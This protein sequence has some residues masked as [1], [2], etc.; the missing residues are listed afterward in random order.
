[1]RTLLFVSFLCLSISVS[2][3]SSFPES[4]IGNYE[5]NL[6]IYAVD[7][8]A[9]NL[10]MNLDIIKTEKD[11]IFKWVI[12]YD[13]KGK[14]DLRSYE[15]KVLDKQKGHYQIDEK[16]SIV[17]DAY[18]RNGIFTSFF[19]VSEVFILAT[20]TMKKEK[21]IIFEI[22]SAKTKAISTTGGTKNEE[23]EIPIVNSYLV[24]GRQRAVLKKAI[25]D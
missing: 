22:I 13:F 14:E 7:S 1:M 24:N 11:S 3:Q 4:W 12:T 10:K 16:N 17:I 19:S 25:V 2:S 9:M 5:G 18:F 23:E 21:A 6:E 8:I 15:L 20:Y